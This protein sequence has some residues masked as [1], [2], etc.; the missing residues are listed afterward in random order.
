LRGGYHYGHGASKDYEIDVW[1]CDNLR[2][3][4][5]MLEHHIVV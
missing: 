1:M 2:T 4:S 3:L 5:G